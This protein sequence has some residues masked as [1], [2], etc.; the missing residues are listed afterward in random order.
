M[1]RH[2]HRHNNS[3]KRLMF[4]TEA[5]H[6]DAE[7]ETEAEDQLSRS[8]QFDVSNEDGYVDAQRS[9]D[10]TNVGA[11]T[12]QEPMVVNQVFENSHKAMDVDD[13]KHQNGGY[14]TH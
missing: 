7:D 3:H 8:K 5:D 6:L 14:V 9:P 13:E 10:A 4:A 2:C 1:L 11:E 12:K